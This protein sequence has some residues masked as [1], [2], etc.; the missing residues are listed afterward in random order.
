M[1]VSSNNSTT[2]HF[3]EPVV[4]NIPSATK[5][6]LPSASSSS[7]SSSNSPTPNH[8]NGGAPIN[9]QSS[10]SIPSNTPKNAGCGSGG[11]KN[12]SMLLHC[13]SEEEIPASVISSVGSVNY[14][15][16]AAQQMFMVSTAAPWPV[17]SS[18]S[19]VSN[20][21]G[22][23]KTKS[24]YPTT[25]NNH[26]NAPTILSI[27][28]SQPS[29]VVSS[30]KMVQP[31]AAPR[32]HPK[33]RKFDL[34]ELDASP[35]NTPIAVSATNSTSLFTPTATSSPSDYRTTT[36]SSGF[37]EQH[38][39]FAEQK[40][41]ND[42]SRSVPPTKMVSLAKVL[43]DGYQQQ[44]H[45]KPGLPKSIQE[46]L[47]QMSNNSNMQVL[48]QSNNGP[49]HQR[50]T[51]NDCWSAGVPPNK[52][53]SLANVLDDGY[54]FASEQPPKRVMHNQHVDN[55]KNHHQHLSA[56][57]SAGF[58]LSNMPPNNTISHSSHQQ[59][60]PKPQQQHHSHPAIPMD[61]SI[62]TLDLM[63]WENHRVLAKQGAYFVAG[64]IRTAISH[65][66]VL[67]EL[68]HPEGTTQVYTDVLDSGRFNVISDACPSNSDVSAVV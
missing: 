46:R 54:Q 57:T 15:K 38:S 25:N 45:H 17:T 14:Q 21:Y 37:T 12:G 63:Q 44:Q 11:A 68:N 30:F 27:A 55:T 31:S 1:H 7:S 4:T 28:S 40:Q 60:Q 16:S 10:Y 58:V 52:M 20:E 56:S 33:K 42:L 22:S 41:A 59:Y 64:C 39:N 3:S 34:A 61:S 62:D 23:L 51:M 65:N 8:L 2:I 50:P 66:S 9:H 67:V 36:S 13:D 19:S 43:D 53:V 26:N 48:D 6:Q 29:S 24:Q 47:Q 32:L 5:P 18:S 49:E 35:P